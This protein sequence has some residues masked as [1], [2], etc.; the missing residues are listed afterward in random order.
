MTDFATDL[1]GYKMASGR[2]GS[3]D[4]GH[5]GI[6]VF[7]KLDRDLTDND[8][9]AFYKIVD[10]IEAAL[11]TETLRLDPETARS[12]KLTRAEILECFPAGTAGYVEEVP[13]GYCSRYC[14]T[15]K[16]WYVVT[17]PRGR[18]KIGWRKSVLHLEWTDSDIKGLAKE[19]FPKE[20]AW[21]GYET[22]QFDQVIHAHGYEAATDYLHRLLAYR[23][24][25]K[26][27]A[28]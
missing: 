2:D 21:P 9:M 12:A 3:N 7:I 20:E 11:M 15:F 22:T 5:F 16:P 18:I 28:K 25:E 17:T 6:K 19:V 10:Q 14:C 13:N 8:R 24:A 26:A 23:P 1:K 4:I 27:A